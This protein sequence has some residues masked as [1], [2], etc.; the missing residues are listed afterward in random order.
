MIT[1]A[2]VI[3]YYAGGFCSILLETIRIIDGNRNYETELKALA[4]ADMILSDGTF[5]PENMS[6]QELLVMQGLFT[7]S[8]LPLFDDYI[9]DMVKSYIRCKKNIVINI[10]FLQYVWR[11]IPGLVFQDEVKFEE[12]TSNNWDPNN[13]LSRNN[14]LSPNIF[15]YLPKVKDIKIKTRYGDEEEK[16]FPFDM[17]EFIETMKD[18]QSWKK[19]VIQQVMIGKEYEDK[20]WINKLWTSDSKGQDA[21]I[22]HYSKYKTGIMFDKQK[23]AE[24]SFESF[25]ISRVCL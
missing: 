22:S 20:S 14:L 3:E 1:L 12:T 10:D 17:Y 13:P 16:S 9:H 4:A 11:E 8:K 15:E 5:D 6:R 18:I 7:P 25:I 2:A 21:L 24:N 23:F 19:I